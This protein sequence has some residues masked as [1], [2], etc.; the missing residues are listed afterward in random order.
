MSRL[1]LSLLFF[2]ISFTA[3]YG[4]EQDTIYHF[5]NK[6]SQVFW[7]KVYETEKP[8]NQL[9]SAI[10]SGQGVLKRNGEFFPLW[11]ENV[12]HKL[13]LCFSNFFDFTNEVVVNDDW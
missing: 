8:I 3:I 9:K 5:V 1:L 11:I 2:S 10:P 13:D 12:A 4:Q 7:Q 6:N